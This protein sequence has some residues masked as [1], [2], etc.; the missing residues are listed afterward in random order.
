MENSHNIEPL[1]NRY[2][3]R[4]KAELNDVDTYN[5]MYESLKANGLYEDAATIERI[6]RDEYNHAKILWYIL[7]EHGRDVSSDIE[8]AHLWAKAKSA[9]HIA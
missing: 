5:T 4:L 1:L 6:A 8:I 3:D 2:V 7:K 9:F